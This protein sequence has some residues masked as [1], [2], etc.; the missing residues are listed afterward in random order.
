MWDITDTWA[1]NDPMPPENVRKYTRLTQKMAERAKEAG[2]LGPLHLGIEYILGHPEIDAGPLV[3][4]VFPYGDEAARELLAFV[5]QLI[6]KEED[7][8][9]P[10]GPEGVE[11]VE[12]TLPEWRK[13]RTLEK[14]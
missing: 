13:Q 14:K 2:E 8:V 7:P 11:W 12:L 6:W 9:P 5:R 3:A 10:E 4:Q 1:A